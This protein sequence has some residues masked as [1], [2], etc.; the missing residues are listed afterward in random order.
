M[1]FE[2]HTGFGGGWSSEEVW[3]EE[4]GL[5][6]AHSVRVRVRGRGRVG[7]GHERVYG[8]KVDAW[9]KTCA[10][11]RLPFGCAVISFTSGFESG[12]SGFNGKCLY[13]FTCAGI[14][15]SI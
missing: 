12:G 15:T 7:L 11:C 13:G 6:G 9:Y 5:L 2:L 14:C 8:T 10:S 3:E 4:C 1:T